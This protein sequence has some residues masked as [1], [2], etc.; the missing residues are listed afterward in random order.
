MDPVDFCPAAARAKS[1]ARLE[2]LFERVEGLMAEPTLARNPKLAS[3]LEALA[4]RLLMEIEEARKELAS[5]DAVSSAGAIAQLLAAIR[6]I[7]VGDDA[8]RKRARRL[9]ARAVR[10]LGAA[11][12]FDEDLCRRLSQT[13][14]AEAPGPG[15][16]RATAS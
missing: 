11:G 6:D 2:G 12:L 14:L 3:E 1:L 5:I 4:C 15:A 7:R 13:R 8:E 10:F 16:G 9:E